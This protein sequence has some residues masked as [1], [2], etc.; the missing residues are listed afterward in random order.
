MGRKTSVMVLMLISLLLLISSSNSYQ[1]RGNSYQV[2]VNSYQSPGML[3]AIDKHTG[4]NQLLQQYVGVDLD[5]IM[6]QVQ[7]D[8]VEALSLLLQELLHLQHE[9]IA[10]QSSN[11]LSSLLIGS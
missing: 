11:N 9:Q 8:E 5:S 7:G 4:T 2:G 6:F 10:T 3:Q 1:G